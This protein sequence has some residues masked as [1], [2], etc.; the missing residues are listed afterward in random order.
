MGRKLGMVVVA[1][2]ALL[3]VGALAGPATAAQHDFV[4]PAGIACEGF[5]LGVDIGAPVGASVY[6]EFKDRDGNI[7]RTLAAGT[8]NALTFTNLTSGKVLALRSNGA[9]TMTRPGPDGLV[10]M[11]TMGHLVVILFPTDVPAGPTTILHVGRTVVTVDA[12]GNFTVES[13]T[14][15]STDI[16]AALK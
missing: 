10:T 6:R 16:C 4:F 13:A 5:D 1:A 11:T 12:L 2:S 7:V 3:L 8:G 15:R 9:V 14:G